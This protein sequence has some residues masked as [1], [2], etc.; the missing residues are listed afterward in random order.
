MLLNESTKNPGLGA[1][2]SGDQWALFAINNNRAER[3]MVN[4]SQ[5]N[6]LSAPVLEG[7]AEG[8]I[9]ITHP[10]DTIDDGVRVKTR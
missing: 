4:V 1:F 6:G 3:R 7:L 10:D 5:R 2:R 9:V 8:E